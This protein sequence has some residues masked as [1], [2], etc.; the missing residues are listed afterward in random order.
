[1]SGVQ[2]LDKYLEVYVR[3]SLPPFLDRNLERK[4]GFNYLSESSPFLVRRVF[5]AMS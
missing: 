4:H 1:M 3:G 5:S 2:V